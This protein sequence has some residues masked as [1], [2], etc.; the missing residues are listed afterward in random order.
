MFIQNSN[1]TFF[2]HWAASTLDTVVPPY[3]LTGSDVAKEF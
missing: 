2:V 1:N 3:L